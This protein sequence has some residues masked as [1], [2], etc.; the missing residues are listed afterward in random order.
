[1]VELL[2]SAMLLNHKLAVTE[3]LLN[4]QRG[5]TPIMRRT[6]I[7]DSFVINGR[8]FS[9]F[10]ALPVHDAE[11]LYIGIVKYGKSCGCNEGAIGVLLSICLYFLGSVGL[12]I[13]LTEPVIARWQF[14]V[15]TAIA[16]GTVGKCIGLWWAHRSFES[17]QHEFD[18]LMQ[19][20]PKPKDYPSNTNHNGGIS[21]G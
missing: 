2:N 19:K 17:L 6:I 1:V 20:Q 8:T 5:A 11:R 7:P 10:H 21:H 15:V 13:L 12:P 14:G 4:I 18:A 9:G 16:G 3:M